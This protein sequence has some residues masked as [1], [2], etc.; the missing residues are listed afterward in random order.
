MSNRIFGMQKQLRV[1]EKGERFFIKCYNDLNP[2]KSEN[3]EVDIFINNN[4]SVE[5][6][7]DQY[8]E[9]D[10][11]NFFIELIGSSKT[12]KLGGAHLSLQNK[13]DYFVYHYA[14]DLT[15]YW[16]RPKD[17]VQFI[18]ENGYK[19]KKKEIRNISWH[20]TGILIPRED[21]LHLAVRIDKF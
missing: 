8:S 15:F 20:S 19:Y 4:E 16:F 18:D 13:I 9:E 3:R 6:K 7:S 1:G 12:G 2:V 14:N 21:V 11:K 17:L 5:L 10:T